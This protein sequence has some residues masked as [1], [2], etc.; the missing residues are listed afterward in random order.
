[1]K[2]RLQGFV[3]G[4]I[5]TVLVSSV[6][7]AAPVGKAITAF[8]N[9]I[10]IY[11]D[12][13]KIEPKD[14]N[15]KTVEP[16]ICEGTTYL[17]VRA[18]A[19]ALGKKVEWDGESNTVY[20]SER[21]EEVVVDNA[22]DFLMAIGSN[23]KIILKPGIYNLSE[24]EYDENELPYG[25]TSGYEKEICISD[26]SNLIIEGPNEEMAEIF[27]EPRDAAVLLF[28]NVNNIEIR[29]IKA[30]HTPEEYSCNA[31]V[32]YFVDSADINIDN[33]E[34]YGCGSIGLDISGVERLTLTN[35]NIN[36]CSLRAIG[37]ANSKDITLCKN[38]IVDHGA[39]ANIFSIE[40]SQGVRIE[41][42][43]MTRN[44]YIC[45]SYIYAIDSDL[46]VSKCKIHDNT[47][48]ENDSQVYFFETTDIWGK[49]NST[50][51][52]EDTEFSNNKYDCIAD[53]E[54]AVVYERCSFKNNTWK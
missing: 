6:A 46:V 15:G 24:A 52:V 21:M 17:P 39:Y 54:S 32:L 43:E 18:V 20:I 48:V 33:C 41:E 2:E 37:I 30:G 12:G 35:S 9:E 22:K 50:I 36:S 26:I 40:K 5:S 11:V 51:L 45:W 14:G 34:L 29:N 16:F 13:N 49:S 53:T 38:E 42:C 25:V 7:F 31:G 27:V 44:N 1:M 28:E 19:E 47:Q 10:K 3:V 4:V 8:Y 23:K